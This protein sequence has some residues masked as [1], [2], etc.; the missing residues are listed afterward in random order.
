MESNKF[1][2]ECRS[3]FGASSYSLYTLVKYMY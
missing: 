1:E 3:L 2:D